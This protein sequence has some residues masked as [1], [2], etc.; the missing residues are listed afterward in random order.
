VGG[1][2]G[3]GVV[4]LDRAGGAGAKPVVVVGG[5]FDGA[6]CRSRGGRRWLVSRLIGEPV[7]TFSSG[8]TCGF[9]LPSVI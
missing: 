6:S 4:L 7:E 5:G 3:R 8:D 2:G 1:V 9:L